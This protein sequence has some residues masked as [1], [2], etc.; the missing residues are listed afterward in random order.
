MHLQICKNIIHTF[1]YVRQIIKVNF[2]NEW[3]KILSI[4]QNNE[5]GASTIEK[6]QQNTVKLVT[7]GTNY[8]LIYR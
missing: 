2:L 8:N 3:E 6:I 7:E 5:G 1:I 4:F